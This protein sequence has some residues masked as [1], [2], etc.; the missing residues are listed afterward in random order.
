MNSA[1]KILI[2]F[3]ITCAVIFS[4]KVSMMIEQITGAFGATTQYDVTI[5]EIESFRDIEIASIKA[6]E[7]VTVECIENRWNAYRCINAG[8]IEGTGT[9]NTLSDGQ[10]WVLFIV[11]LLSVASIIL[12]LWAAF[13]YRF[14]I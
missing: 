9:S 2:V 3:V 10:S 7:N 11:I 12:M 5:T 1:S 14:F 4:Y 6:K 8:G 13:I